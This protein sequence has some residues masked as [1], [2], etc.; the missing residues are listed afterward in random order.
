[1]ACECL[2]AVTVILAAE[3]A[4]VFYE[5]KKLCHGFPLPPTKVAGG[6]ISQSRKW[7]G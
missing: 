1:M 2:F 3:T 6:A 7:N 5:E 4:A